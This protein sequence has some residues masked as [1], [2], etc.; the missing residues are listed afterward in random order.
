ML[1]ETRIDIEA[2]SVYTEMTGETRRC[3]VHTTVSDA[4]GRLMVE[5]DDGTCDYVS[6][7][8]IR[9]LDSG[10]MFDDFLWEL[11]YE[12]YRRRMAAEGASHPLD[13]LP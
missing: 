1:A 8:H 2:S 7:C 9:F 13:A 12:D 5:Y 4:G 6:A 11:T 10:E 3:F